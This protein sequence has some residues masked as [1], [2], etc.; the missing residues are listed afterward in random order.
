MREVHTGF[1][2]GDLKERD[3]LEEHGLE[4]LIRSEPPT[5]SQRRLGVGGVIL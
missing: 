4:G 1:R 3:R 2:R 5:F